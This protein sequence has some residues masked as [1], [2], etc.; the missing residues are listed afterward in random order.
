MERRQFARADRY[1]ADGIAYCDE[2][3]L[4]SYGLYLRAWRSRLALD[5][6]R[7]RAA[8]EQAAE[9]NA[10]PQASPPT[11]IVAAV[12]SG[13]LAARTGDAE[14]GEALLDDAL[15]AAK[16]TG[17]LQRLAP[18]AAAR[19]E[20]AWLRGDH[21]GVEEATAV[22][23]NLAAG[24]RHP[25]L[26]GDVAVWRH[27]LGLSIPDGIVS[28]PVVAELAGDAAGAAAL[29]T[30]LGCPYDAALALAGATDDVLLRRGLTELQRLGAT[31]AARLVARQMRAQGV[32]AIPRGPSRAARENAA[33]LTARELEVLG[34]LA[35]SLRNAEIAQRL[36]V[37]TRTVDHHVS[38]I[39]A[40]LGARTRAQ[41]V[42]TAH[43]LG[44][45][46]DR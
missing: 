37:S 2:H 32:R 28:P 8:A 1:L 5:S 16:P 21:D 45:A 11:R 36:V 35:Q 30:D 15:A 34:L 7:F 43:E 46:K 9:V 10:H 27:R 4:A 20:A 42:A 22:V 40:K 12:V 26:L 29:W 38:R 6:G 3:D 18:V 14:R 17:E 25:W 33:G 44:L 39:L 19:A 31:R 13:L 41:A 23:A 24:R